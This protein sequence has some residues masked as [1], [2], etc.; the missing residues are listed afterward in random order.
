MTQRLLAA[1]QVLISA[2][3]DPLERAR[4]LQDRAILLARL[5]KVEQARETLG[6]AL[7]EMPRDAPA[8]VRLRYEYADAIRTYF[9]KRFD[10]ARAA[11]LAIAERAR[12]EASD[13]A[14]V[15]ECESALALFMQREC[16]VRAASRYAHAVLANP[17]ATLEARYRALLALGSLHQDAY[18]YEEASRLYC[19][20]EEVVRK[21]DDDIAMASCLQRSAL[22]QAAH[23]RQAA[24]LGELDARSL[25]EAVAALNKSIAF[26]RSLADGPDMT[27]DHLLLAEM[28]VLQGV[29]AEAL[30]LYDT[31]LPSAEGEGFLHEV[32]GAMSDRGQCCLKLGR[33]EEGLV[34]L[35]T[36]LQRV[37]E[38][39]PADIRAIAH[40]NMAE[41]LDRLGRGAEARQHRLMAGIAW[42]TY[43]HEQREARRLLSGEP[44]ERLH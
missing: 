21:L 3:T 13:L 16:D 23:V 6:N 8:P 22:T 1:N 4:H 31:Y 11:M 17:Q 26:A 37:D 28:K 14:L 29:P 5:G 9:S 44:T 34:Q 12:H 43:A 27:L 15:S 38:S 20:A 42:D 32:T 7:R 40:A 24:A 2:A 35:Q 30:A 41:A 10:E 36:A 18:D 39:T 25:A 19:E 33:V